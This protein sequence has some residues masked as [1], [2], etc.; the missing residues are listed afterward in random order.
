MELGA[1]GRVGGSGKYFQL[2]GGYW[3]K[4]MQG[5]EG[6]IMLS[7][8][9]FVYLLGPEPELLV[10]EVRV[11]CERPEGGEPDAGQQ[12]HGAGEG[13]RRRRRRVDPL[14]Q[15]HSVGVVEFSG[16]EKKCLSILRPAW[17]F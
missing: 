9:C 4:K 6:A 7:D 11:V 3:A 12:L 1:G 16:S 14:H 10:L 5:K 2:H 15:V 13:G 17:N 8:I